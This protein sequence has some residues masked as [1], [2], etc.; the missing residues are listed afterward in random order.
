MPGQRAFG[1]AP[2]AA[3]TRSTIVDALS[4]AHAASPFLPTEARS[5]A[6]RVAGVAA[7]AGIEA[8][9]LRGTLDVGGA[10]LDHLFVVV[11]GC[12]VDAAMP[13]N[14]EGFLAVVRAWVAGD[15]PAAALAAAAA[16]LDL[17]ARVVG[18]F[19]R[20]LRYRGAPLWGASVA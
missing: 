16:P 10:E 12:V 2:L 1:P 13:V 11:D 4:V 14:D 3:G 7:A 6:H 20:S 8:Q 18:T 15:E 9:V 5:V 17:A 19:P